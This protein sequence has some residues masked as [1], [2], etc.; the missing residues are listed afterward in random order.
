MQI[1][2]AASSAKRGRVTESRGA[3][4]PNQLQQPLKMHAERSEAVGIGVCEV[5]SLVE[6]ALRGQGPQ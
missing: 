3:A 1:P 2:E 4:Q 5:G 6:G